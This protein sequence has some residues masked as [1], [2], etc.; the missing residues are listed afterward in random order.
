MQVVDSQI[1]DT[2]QSADSQSTGNDL[3]QSTQR[4][5][6]GYMPALDGVR[7]I[8][9]FLVI[10]HNLAIPTGSQPDGALVTLARIFTNAGWIGV[11]LFF[12]LS[13]FLIT[14]I[15]LQEK[16]TGKISPLQQWR[17]FYVRRFLRIFPLYYVTLIVGLLLLPALGISISWLRDPQEHAAW[18]W[19]F[20][21]N[22]GYAWVE[23]GGGFSH[24]WSLAVEEQ[25]YLAWPLLLLFV[26]RGTAQWI[27][28]LLVV[29]ATLFRIALILHSPEFASKAA[30]TLTVAR[31]DALAIGALLAIWLRTPRSF[32]RLNVGVIPA[33]ML[34]VAGL[35]LVIGV[36]HNF[37]PVLLPEQP[38][39]YLGL[40][41]QSLAALLS[42]TLIVQAVVPAFANDWASRLRSGVQR[43]LNVGPLRTLGKYSFA[44]YVFHLPML[45]AWR[46]A[47]SGFLPVDK[48]GVLPVAGVNLVAV[49]LLSLLAARISWQMLE[50]PCLKLKSR[51]APRVS[52]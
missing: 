50:R 2:Q 32:S 9:I 49:T 24:F 37:A 6:A 3:F 14:S 43:A 15:L 18:Y 29:F 19:F 5:L 34:G 17:Q 38:R 27:C 33:Q 26:T 1:L 11:Q 25:F 36:C 22:W 39:D 46:N 45:I 47:T 13:G 21:S 51:L 31:M 44:V 10:A 42:A 40:F 4:A 23:L 16:T 30:Y 52:V 28:L 20:V 8:A 35:L 7:G 48:W 12:V 41:N